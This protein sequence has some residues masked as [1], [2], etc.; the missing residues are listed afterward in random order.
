MTQ[1]LGIALENKKADNRN[2]FI[3]LPAFISEL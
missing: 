1:D 2:K 3:E